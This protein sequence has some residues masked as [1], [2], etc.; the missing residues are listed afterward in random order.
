ML[1]YILKELFTEKIRIILTIL[2]VAWGTFSIS[3]MLSVGEGLRDSFG[4]SINSVGHNLLIVTPGVVSHNYDGT[5]AGNGINIVPSTY[6]AIKK[7]V[8]NIKKISQQYLPVFQLQKN[9]YKFTA[10]IAAVSPEYI[11]IHHLQLLSGGRFINPFDI[12]DRR[13]VIV[14]G[15]QAVKK[16]F[17][18]NPNPIGEYIKFN[19]IDMKVIG[20]I[21]DKAEMMG[22]T[23]S[24]AFYC[25]VPQTTYRLVADSHTVDSIAITYIDPNQLPLMKQ[26][27]R[28]IIALANHADPNDL[29]TVNFQDISAQQRKT[30]EFLFGMELFLGIVGGLTLIV[31]GTGIANVMFASVKQNTRMIGLRM[32]I[33]AQPHQILLHY[34]LE[35]LLATAIG[36]I[37]GIGVTLL[38]VYS[39]D[40]IPLHGRVFEV[41]GKPHL[42][43][44]V[45]VIIIVILIL[46]IIG[47]IAGFF[48]AKIAADI[49]PAEALRHG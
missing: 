32:A 36:G 16:L 22:S 49:E 28:T 46:G 6:D 26:E 43:L 15:A 13:K 34:V 11:D 4:G 31:A 29:Q 3:L 12:R 48:P 44:S 40:S 35:S 41:F 5:T 25:W 20:V 14:L 10:N 23:T 9:D 47:F 42:V 18:H 24:D 19:N 39:L 2:A 7:S 33:G 27:I 45:P 38:L 37:I 21:Q 1:R 8:S 30:N 17:P